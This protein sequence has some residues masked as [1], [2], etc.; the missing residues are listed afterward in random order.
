MY[1]E[2]CGEGLVEAGGV[3]RCEGFGGFLRGVNGM[4]EGIGEVGWDV[5][6]PYRIGTN[7]EVTGT[8]DCCLR[9]SYPSKE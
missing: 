8:I 7:A 1:Q 2:G 4:E 6:A 3:A 9:W 5:P